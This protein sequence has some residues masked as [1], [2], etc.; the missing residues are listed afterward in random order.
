MTDL[1]KM[2]R[3]LQLI[4][5][6]CGPFKYKLSELAER[7]NKTERTVQRYLQSMQDAGFIIKNENG[8]YHLLKENRD[9][10]MLYD[11][12]H[13]TREEAYV[14]GK[15]I[16][17]VDANNVIKNNLFKKLYALHDFEKAAD[18]FVNPRCGE[19]VHRLLDAI[20]QKHQVVLKNYHS[21]HGNTISDREVEAFEFTTDF[22]SVWCFEIHTKTNKL[23]KTARIREVEILGRAWEWE[24]QHQKGFID[25]FRISSFEKLPVQLKLSL[26]A[27]N[28][29]L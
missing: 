24:N 29:L 28:L 12:L 16:F 15:A 13:F 11:L 26:R 22:I 5:L 18:A 9:G 7:V 14:L 23:F 1:P 25:V 3:L 20:G 6:L 21:A 19:N 8:Y 17:S 2:D 4:N 27:Y 10:A